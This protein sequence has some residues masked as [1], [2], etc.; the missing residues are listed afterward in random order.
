VRWY[1]VRWLSKDRREW[2]AAVVMLPVVLG[3]F[4]LIRT[5]IPGWSVQASALIGAAIGVALVRS[6]MLLVVWLRK[7]R[8][9]QDG[10]RRPS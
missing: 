7:R 3:V 10:V 6:S 9:P 5:I 8:Q 2:T 1:Q 4:V